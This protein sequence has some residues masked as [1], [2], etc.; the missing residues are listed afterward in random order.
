MRALID[1]CVIID[2]LQNRQ[3]F[4]ADAQSIFLLAAQ[5]QLDAYVSAKAITDI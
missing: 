4:S 2:A 5:K 3:P 1:T